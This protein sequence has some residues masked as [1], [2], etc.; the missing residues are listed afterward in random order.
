MKESTTVT[1]LSLATT[2][3]RNV[4]KVLPLSVIN[5]YTQEKN[6]SPA[7]KVERNLTRRN[8]RGP[9]SEQSMKEFTL[10]RNHLSAKLANKILCQKVIECIKELKLE[11]NHTPA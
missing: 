5:R 2:A 4:T 11:K 9:T 7:R 3:G 8:T 10:E 1:N 6:H